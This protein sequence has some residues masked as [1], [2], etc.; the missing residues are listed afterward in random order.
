MI[1]IIFFLTNQYAFEATIDPGEVEFVSTEIFR[2][3]HCRKFAEKRIKYVAVHF[4]KIIMR[5][6]F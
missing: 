3:A 5:L 4:L 1:A 2:H 6:A